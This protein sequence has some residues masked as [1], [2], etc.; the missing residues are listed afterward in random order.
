MSY[1]KSAALKT[2]SGEFFR[3]EFFISARFGADLQRRGT[4]A[5]NKP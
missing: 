2:T 3:G 1:Y 5:P 4:Q